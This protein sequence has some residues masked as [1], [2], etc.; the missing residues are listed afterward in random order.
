MADPRQLLDIGFEGWDHRPSSLYSAFIEAAIAL[1]LM[2]V[3]CCLPG[4]GVG[5]FCGTDKNAL[6]AFLFLTAASATL[7]GITHHSLDDTFDGGLSLG[8]DW[9]SDNTAWQWTWLSSMLCSVLSFALMVQ[10]SLSPIVA[11]K[12]ASANSCLDYIQFFLISIVWFLSLAFAGLVF[13]TDRIQNKI[14]DAQKYLVLFGMLMSTV[15]AGVN[16]T[17]FICPVGEGCCHWQRILLAIGS[18]FSFCAFGIVAF[19]PHECLATGDARSGCPWPED[20]NQNAIFHF[21]IALSC[22]FMFL[23]VTCGGGGKATSVY[24]T[25]PINSDHET[26]HGGATI[27]SHMSTKEARQPSFLD[28][29]FCCNRKGG[30]PEGAAKPIAADHGHGGG[31]HGHGGGG[32][33]H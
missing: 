25:V 10:I 31:G 19:E 12:P 11:S 17:Y 5:T 24:A 26:G 14:D 20:F 16:I 7:F 21:A 22:F 6:I 1:V 15:S 23:G 13:Y 2:I 30:P 4:T 33:G 18:A 29:L 28:T 8:S 9:T 27:V 32:H 3:A